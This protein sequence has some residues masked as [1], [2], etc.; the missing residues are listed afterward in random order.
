MGDSQSESSVFSVR[1]VSI[2]YYLA[3]PIPGLGVSYSSFQGKVHFSFA[4]CYGLLSLSTSCRPWVSF[5]FQFWQSRT[6]LGFFM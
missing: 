4:L 6:G 5:D 2:D 3:P 1:I